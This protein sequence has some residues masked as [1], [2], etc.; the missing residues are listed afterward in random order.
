MK[1]EKVHMADTGFFKGWLGRFKLLRRYAARKP[2]QDTEEPGRLYEAYN[3]LE[4]KP[5]LVLIPSERAP[6]EPQEEWRVCLRSQAMPPHFVL[7]VE[8]A[9]SSGRLSQLRGML[10]QLG[11]A[12]GRLANDEEARAHL[13]RV[14]TGPMEFMWHLP[15]SAWK[16]VRAS[17]WRTA[18]AIVLMLLS[19]RL[20]IHLVERDMYAQ[21]QDTSRS[22]V[23]RW[24]AEQAIAAHRAPALINKARVGQAPIAYPLPKAPFVDQAKTPCKPNEDEVEINGGCWMAL[25]RRPPCRE[26]QAEYRGKCYL[27]VSA[28]SR[29]R[30]PQSLHR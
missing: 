10:E 17:R 30:E 22:S 5:A 23:E 8:K 14:P 11:T 28:S 1:N 4:D 16:W 6:M 7:E 3:V 25:E 18:A 26:N 27:P 19:S 12:V 9:P 2:E 21:E 15:A 20:A 29:T 13:T 24:R